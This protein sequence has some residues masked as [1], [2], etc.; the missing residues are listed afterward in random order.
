MG[1]IMKIKENTLE[2][3]ID[4]YE[5]IKNNCKKKTKIRI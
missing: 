4:N 5:N 2:I 3:N 1:K